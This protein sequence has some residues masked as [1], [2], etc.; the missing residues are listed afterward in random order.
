MADGK[1]VVTLPPT[2]MPG[3]HRVPLRFTMNFN[4]QPLSFERPVAFVVEPVPPAP[5]Q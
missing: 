3:E 2:A 4:G 1:L 5:Q